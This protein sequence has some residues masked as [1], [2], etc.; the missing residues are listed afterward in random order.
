MRMRCSSKLTQNQT[1]WLSALTTELNAS[2][3][4]AAA[5][6]DRAIAK[7]EELERCMPEIEAAARERAS[8]EFSDLDPKRF[9]Q[10]LERPDK[11]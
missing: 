11:T 4:S 2:A 10:L 8:I 7:L 9:A 5:A 3:S 6:M 1:A